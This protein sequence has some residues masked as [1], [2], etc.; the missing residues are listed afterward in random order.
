MPIEEA[1]LIVVGAGQGGRPLAVDYAKAGKH[2]V[3]FERK[4]LGGTCVNVGC[5]PS[6]AF[7]ASAHNA[8]R[9][10]A[11]GQIGVHC[12]ITL[13]T[14]A[15]MRR[16]NAVR[17]DWHDGAERSL[18]DAGVH[19]VMGEARFVGERT[20]EAEGYT[21]R[22]PLVVLDTGTSPACPPIDGL[23]ELPYLTNETFFD[24][25]DLPKSIIIIGGGYVGLE[26][27]Q[28]M[29]RLGTDVTILE[30]GPRLIPREDADAT[31]VL[32]KA[33]RDDGVDLRIGKSASCV[34]RGEKLCVRIEGG[35]E[36]ETDAILVAA[37]RTPNTDALDCAKSGIE[38]DERKFVKVDQSLRTTCSGVYA[39]GEVAGQPAFT[40]VAWE[41]YR[42]VKAVIE[43][44]TRTR[45]DRVLGYSTFT[46]PQLG[47]VG[48]NE[49]EAKRKGRDVR[50]VTY[51]LEDDA[52]GVE[53]NL[54]RGFYRLV[55]D[56]KS[57]AILGATLVG[58]EAGEIV[59]TI[60]AHME[61][62]ST[63]RVLERSVHIHPTFNEGLP[64]L[65]RLL[66]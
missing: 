64:S 38:L 61:A 34:R 25:E 9:A 60:L 46:E 23:S 7:L 37:G 28:G 48:M 42:R 65:A 52:R 26:L 1:D 62:G 20:L 15:I 31:E 36:I 24:L 21:A 12:E 8:G 27:G 40:H 55:V 49:E 50:V 57:E 16:V 39:M 2:V 66:I 17:R 11:A 45:D 44:G 43:G 54:T 32:A 58:Y 56:A 14:R 33:L 59:H 18:S 5:T 53:W 41:D 19:V 35:E 3:L 4:H 10:R 30:T 51:Q 29:Q 22:A 13:D 47:R 63:W 6:K